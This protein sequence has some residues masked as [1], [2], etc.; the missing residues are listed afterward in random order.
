[1]NTLDFF[2]MAIKNLAGAKGRS[3][4]TM[5]G[6]IIGIFSVITLVSM[7]EGLKAFMYDQIASMGTGPNYLEIHAGKKGG[8]AF[9]GGKI[10]YQD[11]KAIENKAKFVSAVDPRVMRPA[12]FTYGNKSFSVPMVMGVTHN[13]PE[14]FNWD[15]SEGKFISD[16]DVESS[17]K[18]CVLGKKIVKELF[19]SF[20]PI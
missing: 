1:M 4:L 17:R 16:I 12:K 18:V 15:A 5:L 11:A 14:T 19:G 2:K 10:T 3:F 7:G 13:M 20:S 6:I 9:F 8:M